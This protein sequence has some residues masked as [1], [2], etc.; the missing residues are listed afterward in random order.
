M[1]DQ[2]FDTF[3][4]QAVEELHAK[5]NE[6][7]TKTELSNYARWYFSQEDELLQF[8]DENDNLKLE[9]D[10]ITIGTYSFN[11]KSWLW[12]WANGYI[13]PSLREKAFR[14]TELTD[15][16]GYDVFTFSKAFALD[17][18]LILDLVAVSVKHLNALGIY[19]MPEESVESALAI[20]NIRK[21]A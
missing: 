5:Q 8:F 13:P 7:I 17:E 19:R 4:Q 20:M 1:N 18:A 3:I 11:D 14:L 6:F 12:A 21:I 16:T 15:I 2:E 10:V 9:L